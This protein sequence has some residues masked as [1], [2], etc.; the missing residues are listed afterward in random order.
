MG[1]FD[2]LAGAVMSSV[3]GQEKGN[4]VKVAMELVQQQG[5]LQGVLAKFQEA[6]LANEVASWISTGQNLPIS[7]EQIA[8]VL[9]NTQVGEIAQRVGLNPE[10]LKA[11]LA[12][13]LPNLVDR[14]S[15]DGRLPADG[16]L[17]SRLLS[18]LK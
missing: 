17:M 13:Q 14:L 11:Q 16:E 18:L 1:L 2:S 4:L 8:Q 15:P 12:E 7:A 9:G 5:G 10:A 3:L 6:G